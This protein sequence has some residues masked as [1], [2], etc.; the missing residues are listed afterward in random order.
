MDGGCNNEIKR[1]LL[2]GRKTITNLD[3]VLK[4]RDITLPTKICIVKAL[5]FP[6]VM[7]RCENWTTKKAEHQ[8]NDAFKLWCWRRPLDCKEIKPV[9][10]EGNQSWIFVG[11]TD[12]EPETPILWPPDAKNWLFRKHPDA[13]N[14]WRQEKGATEGEMVAWHHQ[15]N[16]H[17]FEQTIGDSEGQGSLMCCSLW[18]HKELDATE[19]PN[20][21]NKISCW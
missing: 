18:D 19:W 3:S 13:G 20:S 14:D 7:Y 12:A 4:S 1:H 6:I 10:P 9:N 8:R 17:E 15:L 11:K 2:L 16:G 5:V 21:N